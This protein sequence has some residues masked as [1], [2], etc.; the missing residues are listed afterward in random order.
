MTIPLLAQTRAEAAALLEYL[1]QLHPLGDRE[2]QAAHRE[3]KAL[4]RAAYAR[5]ESD[6]QRA[7]ALVTPAEL[8]VLLGRAA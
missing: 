1:D 8:A 2:E 6:F 7:V 3:A 5:A 4:A